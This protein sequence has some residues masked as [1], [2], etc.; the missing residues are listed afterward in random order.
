[1]WAMG[2]W[3]CE[4]RTIITPSPHP[5]CCACVL[6]AAISNRQGKARKKELVLRL[7][8]LA[9]ESTEKEQN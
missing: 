4:K 7:G 2:G 8:F 9:A 5:Q 1:M 6:L 3:M